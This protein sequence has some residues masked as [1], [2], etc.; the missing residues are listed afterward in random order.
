MFEMWRML[1]GNRKGY[2]TKHSLQ[3]AVASVLGIKSKWMYLDGIINED[4]TKGAKVTTQ[5]INLYEESS[6][7]IATQAQGKDTQM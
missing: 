1:K 2:C 5:Q 7:V 4:H 3:V 6:G